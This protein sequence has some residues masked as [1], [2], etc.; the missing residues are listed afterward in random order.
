MS[1]MPW[2]NLSDEDDLDWDEPLPEV[3]VLTPDYG[4]ELPLWGERWGNIDGRFTRFSRELLDRLAAWQQDFDDNFH[5]WESGWRS[6]SVRDRWARES[7]DL[8]TAV[9]AELGT[10]SRLVVDLWP[11]R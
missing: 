8:A 1:E 5:P 2:R 6:A 11:L 4:A 7:D 10:R 9:R 3:I